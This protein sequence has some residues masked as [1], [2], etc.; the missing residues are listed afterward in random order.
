MGEENKPAVSRRRLLRRA[1]T[2]AAGMGVVGAASAVGATPALAANNDPVLVGG[3]HTGTAK[4]SLTTG[5][6]SN[7]AL[8]LANPNTAGVPLEL[9]PLPFTNGA[10]PVN[11]ANQ[12]LGATYTDRWGDVHVVGDQNGLSPKYD[13]MLY[14]PTWATATY[15]VQGQRLVHTWVGANITQRLSGWSADSIGRVIPKYT[16][17]P[18]MWIDLTDKVDA[19]AGVAAIQL[20]LTIENAQVQAGVAAPWASMWGHGDTFPGTS[21]ISF[22]YGGH[23][24][25]N[26]VQV[27]IGTDGKVRFKIY[28]RALVVID[29]VGLVLSDGLAQAPWLFG[30]AA[31]QGAVGAAAASHATRRTAP[32]R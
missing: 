4:T 21:S 10:S 23:G 15:P 1:G 28:A 17:G 9:P 3:T 8:K 29:M 11:P 27:P 19:S 5:D 12:Q 31:P 18:D 24:T 13:L 2:V 16:N 20:N 32:R 7:A 26:F 6:A 25:S 22:Q 14:S 30:A